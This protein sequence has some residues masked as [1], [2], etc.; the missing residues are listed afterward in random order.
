MNERTSIQETARDSRRADDRSTIDPSGARSS[1]YYGEVRLAEIVD[2]PREADGEIRV[3]I[4]IPSTDERADLSFSIPDAWTDDE[5]LVVLLE[6]YGYGPGGLELLVGERIPVGRDGQSWRFAPG[7]ED[8]LVAEPHTQE[9]IGED[10][11]TDERDK[12]TPI[13]R[14]AVVGTAHLFGFV[15]SLSVLTALAIPI[16]LVAAVTGS[17]L[18]M[19]LFTT[20]GLVFVPIALGLLAFGSYE[21]G[22]YRSP[23]RT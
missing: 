21:L 17:Y 11:R 5:P 1:G 19:T 18:V 12:N 6:E 3:P 7:R 9:P 4:E 20:P 2:Q 16:A 14:Q 10:G 22:R 15:V 8:R 13:H 23:S